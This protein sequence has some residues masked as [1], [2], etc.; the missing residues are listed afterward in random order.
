MPRQ[1]RPVALARRFGARIRSLREAANLT[2]EKLAWDSDLTKGFLSEI[3]SGK[4]LPSVPSMHRIATQLGV[5]IA[6]LFAGD[7]KDPRFEVLDAMRRGD[8][9]ATLAVLR[10]LGWL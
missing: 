8:R 10:R 1:A 4:R 3:E 7:M 9:E 5:D 2:Q 6:D